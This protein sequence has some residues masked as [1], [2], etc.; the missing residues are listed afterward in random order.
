MRKH[1]TRSKPCANENN[2][3]LTEEIRQVVLQDHQY[4][5]PV[6][7][8]PHVTNIINYNTLNKF[9]LN[10]SFDEKMTHVMDYQQKKLLDFEDN[11]ENHFEHR[12][13]R[14]EGNKYR[15]GYF[16]SEDDLFQ[17]INDVTKINK[18]HLEQFNIFYHKAVKRF[19]LYRGTTW[20]S[21][22]EDIGAKELVSLIK[23]Y[24]LNTYELYL[25]RHL[26]GEEARP[27]NRSRLKEHL[28]IYY[29]F[30]AVFEL[31]PAV[32]DEDD[33][34]ILGHRLKENIDNYLG[35]T[36]MKLY[37]EQKKLL[38]TSEANR[39]KRKIINII[40]E[41]TIHNISELNQVVFEILK[42]NESLRQQVI[43]AKHITIE[44]EK[45]EELPC[46]ERVGM[47]GD[48]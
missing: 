5:P 46:P 33:Q 41:N 6:K 34:E 31:P 45:A 26:H 11:L 16:L 39:V 12:I 1:L 28:D 2:L 17:I 36:Y 15:S 7:R 21:Y 24:Y 8:E 13:A 14:L 40:K 29:R 23:S 48:Q 9:V 32:C 43:D 30:I 18:E 3:D 37:S 20:E 47:D 27:L 38:K 25:I 42:V 4:H 22:I 44:R 10:M 35:E 19:Q